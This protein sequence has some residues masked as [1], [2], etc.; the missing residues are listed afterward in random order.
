[1]VDT[2]RD[3]HAFRASLDKR[4]FRDFE[5]LGSKRLYDLA[6][7]VTRFFDFDFDHAF[8]FYSALKGDIYRSPVK[9][10]LFADM[11]EESEAG[12][13]KRTK[14]ADAVPSIGSKMSFLFDY[15]DGWRFR[16]EVIGRAE[17][18][19]GV[20]YPRL[21]NA[22]GKAPPQYPDPDDDA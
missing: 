1:M 18:E 13:V 3:I 10:E 2:E 5:I 4:V 15:G 11:G 19:L 20:R 12:S 7:A 17:K 22:V 14:I 21:V 8:G 6:E 16:L 9:Y